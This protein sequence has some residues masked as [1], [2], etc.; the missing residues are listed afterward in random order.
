MN[1][2]APAS[3]SKWSETYCSLPFH[4]E[5][6]GD[7]FLWNVSVLVLQYN[8]E[9]CIP[10]RHCLEN[11]K[12]KVF[13]QPKIIFYLRTPPIQLVIEFVNV[14]NPSSCPVALGLA[15]AL[16]DIITRNL[17]GLVK[18]GRPSVSRLSRQCGI[19]NVSQ[20]YRPPQP[21][22]GIAFKHIFCFCFV[23]YKLSCIS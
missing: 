20:P 13:L 19:L 10:R 5:D 2:S 8:P 12:S 4:P 1:I 16:K 23:V 22:T 15:Q 6:G 14:P 21:V 11:H 7:T 17:P 9:D 3:R 18:H